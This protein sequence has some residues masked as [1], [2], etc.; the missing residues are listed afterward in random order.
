MPKYEAV[1][2]C[3]TLTV[4]LETAELAERDCPVCGVGRL[5]GPWP[6]GSRFHSD[7][8]IEVSFPLGDDDAAERE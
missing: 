5:L 1:C 4:W 8:R 6:A 3:C 2:D 7:A